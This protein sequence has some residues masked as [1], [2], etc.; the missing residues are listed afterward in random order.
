[1]NGLTALG[2]EI[3]PPSSEPYQVYS[4]GGAAFRAF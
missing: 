1:V 3:H 2:F 4:V